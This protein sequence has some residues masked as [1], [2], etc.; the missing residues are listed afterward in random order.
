MC[1]NNERTGL[2]GNRHRMRDQAVITEHLYRTGGIY[3]DGT[4]SAIEG[5]C[6]YGVSTGD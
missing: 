2:E 1:M 6:G 5:E 4:P 3:G